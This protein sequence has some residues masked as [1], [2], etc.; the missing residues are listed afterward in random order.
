[1]TTLFPTLPGPD[2][3]LCVFW[4]DFSSLTTGNLWRDRSRNRLDAAPQAGFTAPSYGLARSPRGDGYVSLTGAANAYAT[5]PLR[6]YDVAPTMDLTVVYG[7][8]FGTNVANN[9]IFNA[10]NGTKG[11]MS[12]LITT[13]RTNILAYD[14]GGASAQ[15]TDSAD[16]PLTNLTDVGVLCMSKSQNQGLAW[17][18]G[19]P[20]AVTWASNVNPISYDTASVPVLFASGAVSYLIGRGYFLALLAWVPN[21]REAQAM[22]SYI[23][24]E[25]L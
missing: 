22:T 7:I 19:R 23:R 18:N 13:E 20:T 14:A 12:Y 4:H 24:D 15:S 21:H 9:R 17:H 10:R 3:S 25:V 11:F 1:M 6:F 8:A 2:S 5:L 16:V